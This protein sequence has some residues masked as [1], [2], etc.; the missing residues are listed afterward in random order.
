MRQASDTRI[1][2]DSR[3]V[4]EEVLDDCEV[5]SQAGV[6]NRLMIVP[7]EKKAKTV[8]TTVDEVGNNVGVKRVPR[9]RCRAFVPLLSALA[10]IAGLFI[11][12]FPSSAASDNSFFGP[13]HFTAPPL[14]YAKGDNPKSLDFGTP[15]SLSGPPS[16]SARNHLDSIVASQFVGNVGWAIANLGQGGNGYEYPPY[17][18]N[19]GKTWTTDGPYFHGP[20]ANAP[21]WVG[22]LRAYT[23][24]FGVAYA[25]GGQ[26]LYATDD[27]GRHWYA[28]FAFSYI[29][30]VSRTVS[31]NSTSTAGAIRV[32]VSKT[33]NAPAKSVFT[34]SDGGRKW[35]RHAA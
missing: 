4:S 28:S 26:T 23:A 29:V 8:V 15:V 12:A 21:A 30:S 27:G 19:H 24:N 22:A 16:S 18:T 2:E 13:T 5:P 1:R 3:R 10:A 14:T 6:E 32:A 7:Q 35:V 33:G 34:S 11:G 20:W 17:S 31:T 25:R 9:R